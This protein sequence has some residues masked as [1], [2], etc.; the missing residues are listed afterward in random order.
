[1]KSG[2][3]VSI[4]MVAFSMG[5]LLTGCV[6][7]NTPEEPDQLTLEQQIRDLERATGGIFGIYAKNLETGEVINY[8]GSEVLPTASAIKLP[9]LTEFYHQVAQG[10]LNPLTTTQLTDQRKWGGSGI[11]Q[12]YSGKVPVRL[13]DAARLMII[14]SDNTAT[15]LVLDALGTTHSQRL[16]AV[17]DYMTTLGLKNT[18]L[19][20]RLMDW[21]TKTDSPESLRFGIGMSTAEDMGLLL[22]RIVNQ[23]VADS[24]GCDKMLEMLG[25][26]FYSDIIPRFLPPDANIRVHHKTGSVTETR[27]DVGYVISDQ[28]RYVVALFADQFRDHRWSDDNEAVVALAKISRLIWNHFTGDE[29]LEP[30]PVCTQDYYP[31]PG[32]E[33]LRLRLHNGLFPALERAKG[34]TYDGVFYAADRHYSDSTAVVIIPDGFHEVD[35][36]VDLVVHFHGWG[37]DNLHAMGQFKIPQQLGA[38]GKNALFVIAQGPWRARDSFAGKFEQPGGFKAFVKEI[39]EQLKAIDRIQNATPGRIILSGHSGGYR[40][41]TKVLKNRDLYKNIQELF[42]FDA[43]YGLQENYLEF[44]DNGGRIHSIYTEHLAPEHEAFFRQLDSLQIAYKNAWDSDA[45][46][47]LYP[48]SVKHN[49]VMDGTLTQW[50][51]ASSFDAIER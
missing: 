4:L 47:A 43:F 41:I 14:L 24:V 17:N 40:A 3:Y 37:N 48:T 49:E 42:L 27:V 38:S 46:L 18:R 31:Y 30:A 36:K 51:Q 8:N 32:G 10:K 35:G 6:K 12:Y 34:H 25:E 45:R 1:M 26:Q 15:N 16:V 21:S 7:E 22:E 28:G 39:L 13:E 23:E 50:L 29:G 9:I 2:Q 20:N 5:V 19:L 33:W 44:A 11:L